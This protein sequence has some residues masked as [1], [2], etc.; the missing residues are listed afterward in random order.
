MSGN[1]KIKIRRLYSCFCSFSQ[2]GFTVSLTW[3]TRW[4]EC[5]LLSDG[6]VRCPTESKPLS[7]CGWH[8]VCPHFPLYRNGPDRIVPET[9]WPLRRPSFLPLR[10]PQPRHSATLPQCNFTFLPLVF[11][12]CSLLI[13]SPSK[14]P[15]TFL[16]AI[17]EGSEAI[18]KLTQV[19]LFREECAVYL[20]VWPSPWLPPPTPSPT[21]GPKKCIFSDGKWG[22]LEDC[23]RK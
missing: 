1:P 13:H 16:S 22:L 4:G 23:H 10:T 3:V 5:P 18:W 21:L 7:E 19:V 17:L 11:F 20:W 2:Q 14:S 6:C 12:P 9:N 8:P 15:R